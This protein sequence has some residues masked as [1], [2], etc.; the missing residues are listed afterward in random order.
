MDSGQSVSVLLVRC[1]TG[2]QE[3]LPLL[4]LVYGELHA[5]AHRYLRRERSDHTLRSTA[6][7]HEAYLR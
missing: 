6:L 3:A 1:K 7:V 5:I 2:D 4:P